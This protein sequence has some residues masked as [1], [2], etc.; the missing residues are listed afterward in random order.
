MR[1][2]P[3]HT[4]RFRWR[5]WYDADEIDGLCEGHVRRF[6]RIRHG[7]VSYPLSTD[8]L[9]LLIEQEADDLDLYADLSSVVKDGGAVEGV[10]TFVWGRR[11]RV[12]IAQAL[13]LDPRRQARLRTT[14]AHELGHV[15][16]H[17][18]VGDRD[19]DQLPFVPTDEIDPSP[20]PCCTPATLLGT[21][22]AD[23]MEWQ[24][25]YASGAVLMPRTAVCA[26]ASPHA[27]R[28]D[29]PRTGPLIDHVMGH[30]LVSEAAARIRLRQLGYLSGQWPASTATD[31][32]D[33]WL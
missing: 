2:V 26:I 28:T 1:W 5:P 22:R 21:G 14:L 30:F 13:S 10:T 6:L 4:G 20:S 16:L 12:Q 23:W 33:P 24:A 7:L 11:P 9:T 31:G 8:D 17:N 18:V 32:D 25:G 15:L 19:D 27:T 29:G 3:D